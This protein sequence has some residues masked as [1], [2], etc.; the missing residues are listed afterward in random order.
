MKRKCTT[1]YKY[2]ARY[3]YLLYTHP[4]ILETKNED[5]QVILTPW[6]SYI[7]IKQDNVRQKNNL[8][9]INLRHLHSPSSSSSSSSF[10]HIPL[11]RLLSSTTYTALLLSLHG[12]LRALGW[13]VS[14]ITLLPA[15]SLSTSSQIVFH[16]PLT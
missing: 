13:Y 14:L 15:S 8:Y 1:T 5:V 12:L 4:W 16:L 9:Y 2:K 3:S 6:G 10:N 11:S 7:T